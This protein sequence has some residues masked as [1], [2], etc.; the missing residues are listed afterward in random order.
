M[1]KIY[2]RLQ[3]APR[4][5]RGK[6][7]QK[8][9]VVGVVGRDMANRQQLIR[10]EGNHKRRTPGTNKRR[11]PTQ[12]SFLHKLK[13]TLS[14][15]T[16]TEQSQEE[17]TP[18][19]THRVT[20]K[21]VRGRAQ[22]QRKDGHKTSVLL[23]KVSTYF[24]DRIAALFPG[25]RFA[26]KRFFILLI[27]IVITYSATQ[28]WT[29]SNTPEP[30][31]QV[32]ITLSPSGGEQN[33]WHER[34]TP[35]EDALLQ[36][37][38]KRIR[39]MAKS[40]SFTEDSPRP[41]TP[42]PTPEITYAA[43]PKTE[44]PRRSSP[45]APH[46]RPQKNVVYAPLPEIQPKRRVTQK[47][48]TQQTHHRKPTP[49]APKS[50]TAAP[51]PTQDNVAQ[52]RF[53]IQ[54]GQFMQRQEVKRIRSRLQNMGVTSIVKPIQMDGKRAF[55]LEA[56]PFQEQADA[57]WIFRWMRDKAGL[58]PQKIV[59]NRSAKT[60]LSASSQE[61]SAPH[62]PSSSIPQNTTQ[63]PAITSAGEDG[64]YV[65][66]GS[67]SRRDNA[68]RL[69]DALN[70]T[71]ITAALYDTWIRGARYTRVKAGPFSSYEEA[72]AMLLD[73]QKRTQFPA[74]LS[75]PTQSVASGDL[76]LEPQRFTQYDQPKKSQ[77]TGFPP[78]RAGRY[79]VF[80][81]SFS[82]DQNAGRMYRR[83]AEFGIPVRIKTQQNQD[84]SIIHV[85]VGPFSRFE[86]AIWVV[87]FLDRKRIPARAIHTKELILK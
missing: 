65:L 25:R 21:P 82:S 70:R 26:P 85:Q 83:L 69:K 2:E 38:S 28:F 5:R 74:K 80:V 47:P 44:K 31:K 46:V 68:L 34:S 40:G 43:P 10:P 52:G 16:P 20:Q 22:T 78:I 57:R 15:E 54:V 24:S 60:V 84:R 64:Y 50:T 59:D 1:S 87:D 8:D 11:L 32:S 41:Q 67:F 9:R 42:L 6:K 4:A 14:F 86:D 37:A 30:G 35:Q 27:V 45:P 77:P 58:N 51:E 49:V 79:L 72:E 55:L 66:I 71:Q 23:H 63:N 33:S 36:D 61:R 39:D 75:L 7:T 13:Q 29:D 12:P 56:G 53:H 73:V 19:P 48:I 76:Q 62:A 3:K 18:E 81:G 17:S